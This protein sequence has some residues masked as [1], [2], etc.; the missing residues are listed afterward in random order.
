[1]NV[2]DSP[3]ITPL[4][5]C[6]APVFSFIIPTIIF[7][8]AHRIRGDAGY[9]GA[10]SLLLPPLHGLSLSVCAVLVR[11]I[12]FRLSVNVFMYIHTYVWF[13]EVPPALVLVAACVAGTVR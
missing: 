11:A 8:H 2:V 12:S 6:I 1:M 4:N 9:L 10:I 3:S 7:H 5:V 13:R